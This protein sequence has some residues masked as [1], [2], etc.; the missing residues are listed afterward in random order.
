MVKMMSNTTLVLLVNGLF[1][2]YFL[3]KIIKTDYQK[4]YESPKLVYF[5][6]GITFSLN[7]AAVMSVLF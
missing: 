6:D 7:A 4:E 5:F 2:A 3:N 1:A